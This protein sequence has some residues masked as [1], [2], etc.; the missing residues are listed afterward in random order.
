M[1]ANVDGGQ[2]FAEPGGDSTTSPPRYTRVMQYQGD[3]RTCIVTS[4]S[5]ARSKRSCN[6]KVE[7]AASG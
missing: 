5:P 6:W 1:T 7:F 3:A 2:D 4:R